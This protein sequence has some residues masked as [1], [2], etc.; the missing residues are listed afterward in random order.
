[1]NALLIY[2]TKSAFY[3]AALYLVYSVL[4][5]TDTLYGRN[6]LFILL[7]VIAALIF[8]L[9]TLQVARPVNIPY[10]GKTLSEVLVT[11]N[12]GASGNSSLMAFSRIPGIIFLIY[13]SGLFLFGI[14]LIIDFVELIILIIKNQSTGYHIIRFNG[15]NTPGFSALGYV[16]INARLTTEETEEILKHE[17]NHLDHNHFIDIIFIET[18]KVFQWFNPFIH[19]FNRSLRAVHEFQADEGCLKTGI[20]VINYQKLLMNQIFNTRVF[21]ITNSFSNPTLIKKRMIMMTKQRS[22]SLANLKLLMV[23]PSIAIVMIAFSSCKGKTDQKETTTIESIAPTQPPA[24]PQG[25]ADKKVIMGDQSAPGEMPPPLP[26]PPPPPPFD[27][28]NGDTTWIK[29]QIMP[30]FPGG[31]TAIFDFV[32]KNIKYPDAAKNKGIQGKVIVRFKVTTSG[33]IDNISI[34][35]GVDPE[36][37]NEAIRVVSSLPAFKKPGFQNGKPVSVWYMLPINYSLK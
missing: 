20:P 25:D 26:P 2:M 6:R 1:M 36:L 35:K 22:K 37:D 23:L 21:T 15:L 33:K 28:K 16:F 11:G 4:L 19:L 5:S 30:E 17:Q 32:S 7:S 10:F 29:V 14:K 18:V 34:L 12:A 13:L 3:L 9:I 31:D 24:V 8:P 27:V